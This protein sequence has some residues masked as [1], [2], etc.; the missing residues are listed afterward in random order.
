MSTETTEAPET[1]EESEEI[2]SIK[3]DANAGRAA[4]TNQLVEPGKY[5]CNV[6]HVEK[7]LANNGK[8]RLS[9]HLRIIAGPNEGRMIF[10][11]MYLT[12]AAMWKV[13]GFAAAVG[14]TETINPNDPVD[15]INKLVS[16]KV[17]VTYRKDNWTDDE[18][19]EREGRKVSG[20]D[21]TKPSKPKKR[22]DAKSGNS[23]KSGDEADGE[24]PF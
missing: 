14:Q 11:D 22:D 2:T 6:D 23:A 1:S 15:L 10:D 16:R 3:P 7:T 9:V 17:Y 4:G 20:Y 13:Q 5:L 21:S 8:P 19:N 12:K 18:C 24:I